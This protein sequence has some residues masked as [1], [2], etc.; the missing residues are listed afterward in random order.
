MTSTTHF[1]SETALPEEKSIQSSYTPA[2]SADEGSYH[3]SQPYPD[4][5]SS[6]TYEANPL[7]DE[8]PSISGINTAGFTAVSAANEKIRT[9]LLPAAVWGM[10]AAGIALGCRYKS[11]MIG[12][13]FLNGARKAADAISESGLIGNF[14]MQAA[15]LQAVIAIVLLLMIWSC[16]LCAVGQPGVFALI[17][18]RGIGVGCTAASVW[19]TGQLPGKEQLLTLLP[20]ALTLTL[21]VY[22]ACCAV[23]MGNSVFTQLTTGKR[24]ES[25][26]MSAL[27]YTIRMALAAI[28]IAVIW[29]LVWMQGNGKLLVQ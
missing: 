13:V 17:L 3:P 7:Y 2:A 6:D 27:G 18:T 5:Y 9:P 29:A 10:A 28:G 25:R 4:H 14:S 11:D 1:P 15:F 8:V 26:D 16:G 12:D 22:G 21:L 19:E 20:Q 23:R 24:D